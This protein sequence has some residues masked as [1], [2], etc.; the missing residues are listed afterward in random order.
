[1]TVNARF[2]IVLPLNKG[3]QQQKGQFDE[4]YFIHVRP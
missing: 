1:M 2:I 3:T 4:A